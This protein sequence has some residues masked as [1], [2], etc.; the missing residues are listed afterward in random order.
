LSEKI[1]RYILADS[2]LGNR[3]DDYRKVTDQPN[4]AEAVCRWDKGVRVQNIAKFER[5]VVGSQGWNVVYAGTDTIIDGM[6]V[7]LTSD[8]TCAATATAAVANPITTQAATEIPTVP[9]V[10]AVTGSLIVA[11]DPQCQNS[12]W[13]IVTGGTWNYTVAE[14]NGTSSSEQVMITKVWQDNGK[15]F[16]STNSSLNG[17]AQYQCIAGAIYDAN[18]DLVL[19]SEANLQAGYQFTTSHGSVRIQGGSTV[20]TT[21]GVFNAIGVCSGG[22]CEYYAQNVGLISATEKGSTKSLNNLSIPQ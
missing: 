11:D 2:Q 17:N 12:Y 8:V 18:N 22:Y 9:T 21:S 19:P 3:I 10:Q 6:D 7:T 1:I 20:K 16:F 5:K 13:P 4:A 14:T 15:T